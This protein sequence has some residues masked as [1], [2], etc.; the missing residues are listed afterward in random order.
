MMRL[1]ATN[2]T[3]CTITQCEQEH[4]P[5][6]NSQCRST[7]KPQK[8]VLEQSDHHHESAERDGAHMLPVH[9]GVLKQL[10][11]VAN[12]KADGRLHLVGDAL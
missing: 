4:L 7:Y 9:K 8:T 3:K 1:S 10:S 11:V 12:V 6:T 5:A 2:T